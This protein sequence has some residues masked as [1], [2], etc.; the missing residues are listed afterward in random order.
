MV[1]IE[2]RTNAVADQVGHL[3]GVVNQMNHVVNDLAQR[4]GDHRTD[5]ETIAAL[6]LTF[7]RFA[8]DLSAHLDDV[9][10]ALPG[11]ATAEN[12]SVEASAANGRRDLGE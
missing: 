6:A 8:A 1:R 3:A 7:R 12:E 5:T 4:M 2:E 10:A 11:A 9:I